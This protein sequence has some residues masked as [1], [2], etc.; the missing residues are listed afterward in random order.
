MKQIEPVQIWTNGILK[1]AEFLQVTGINDNYESSATNY[2]ALFTLV[3]DAEGV[4]SAGEQ[5]AQ[6]NLTI[7][8]QD[9]IDWGDQPAM[10]INEWIY[11]WVALPEQLNLVILP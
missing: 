2:W 7:S 3:N 4:E 10:A 9:Y 11:D 1:T 5:V 6:G 8:G